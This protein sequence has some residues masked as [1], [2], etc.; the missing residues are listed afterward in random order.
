MRGKEKV[1]YL[2]EVRDRAE[3][4]R[5]LMEEIKSLS[6]SDIVNSELI[7]KCLRWNERGD[8][9]LYAIANRG[10]YIYNSTTGETYLWGGHY[11]EIDKDNTHEDATHTV[12]MLY[13]GEACRVWEE[14]SK[15][16]G[17]IHAAERKRLAD[18]QKALNK[19]AA[20]LRSNAGAKNCVEYSR[21][22]PNGLSVRGDVFDAKPMLLAVKNGVIDLTTGK[23]RPGRQ[24]DYLTKACPVEWQGFDYPIPLWKN[25]LNEVF[26]N[27]QELI[28]FIKKLLGYALTGS[29]EEH[30]FPVF[31]GRG[32]NGKGTII[33]VL[34]H[35][36]GPLINTISSEMLLEQRFSRNSSAPSP[37]IMALKGLRLAIASEAN[38]RSSFS[39]AQVKLLT[40][41][42]KLS[43]R[44]PHDKYQSNF[45]PTHKL[46]LLTND[47]PH[48][49][50][51]DY[52]FWARM[53]LIEFPF[54]FVPEPNPKK[55][56]E[57]QAIKNLEKQLIKE[58]PG[59]LAWLVD[60][61]LKCQEEG[62]KAPAK[63]MA[64][65]E[66]YKKDEDLLSGFIEECCYIDES[67]KVSS[68]QM[69]DAFEKWYKE[70]VGNKP[71]NWRWVGLR[72]KKKY[73]SGKVEGRMW[74]R[75]IGLIELQGEL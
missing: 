13:E 75:G 39:A 1:N 65:T 15:L 49:P 48:C 44:N 29:V 32:R 5:L 74:Y 36:L 58:A 72:L 62:L 41:G 8:G 23:I 25:F 10:K 9:V 38:A 26:D 22:I 57:K 14:R 64:A 42:D 37:D 2:K 6:S 30:I 53:R 21:K 33:N 3:E 24:E 28:D 66:E 17:D 27:D 63:V 40:G 45:A 61:W 19:R 35:I 11:W 51:S 59:I 60:G 54:S 56:Y 69:K 50:D 43:G 47:R 12:A 31:Q 4:E 16:D 18:L 71:P 55:P 52:A 70:N 67:A 46:L 34:I 20:K 73:A 7:R 68:A